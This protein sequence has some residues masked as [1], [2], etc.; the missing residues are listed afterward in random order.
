MNE[1][2]DSYVAPISDPEV[3]ETLIIKRRFYFS[4]RERG[5]P[6]PTTIFPD[7]D[8]VTD[9]G[10][11]IVFPVLV[12]PSMSQLFSRRFGR[13]AFIASSK[14]ELVR[15]LKLVQRNEIDVVVQEFVPG[16]DSNNYAL[17][18]YLD[19]KGRLLAFFARHVLR[20]WPISLG[21]NSAC[22]SIPASKV[23]RMKETASEYLASIGYRGIY[24]AHFKVDARDNTGKLLEINAR[25]VGGGGVGNMFPSECGVNLVLTAYLDALGEE[26]DQ[27][28]EYETGASV[29][30]SVNELMWI[31]A[32]VAQGRFSL[33]EWLSTTKG[34]RHWTIWARDD[35][36]PLLAMY[37]SLIAHAIR[38][39]K[40]I[41]GRLRV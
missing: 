23:S 12:K 15:Y 35:P 13:K 8:D 7:I 4:L 17:D 11:K 2:G 33:R 26:L 24:N 29:L 37:A 9:L 31:S 21:T 18:G 41:L 34:R 20:I 30:N 19:K 36:R 39:R 32:M 40:K 14:R 10:K 38:Q 25:S 22:M 5:V 27:I 1:A 6:H 16:P 28:K 3:L